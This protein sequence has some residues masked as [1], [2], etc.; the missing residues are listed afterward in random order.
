MD[1][2]ARF[3]EGIVRNHYWQKMPE[4][5]EQIPFGNRTFF[6]KYKH[7]DAPLSDAL[8]NAHRAGQLT[9]AHPLVDDDGNVP[10][11]VIDYNGDAAKHFY[12]HA[13][14]VLAALG[15]G[16][17]IT[18]QSATPQH[19]HLYIPCGNALQQ[20]VEMGKIISQ[21]LEEKMNRQW[22]VFP[23]D[24]LPDAYNIINLPYALFTPGGS[25]GAQ[26]A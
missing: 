20:A 2:E 21:K 12:H 3:F 17:L 9:L 8:I 19:L 18:F 11:I 6:S 26:H 7:I 5:A 13:G 22:R 16:E 4:V 23:T 1:R 10:F 15:Y 25:K 14:K 24:T